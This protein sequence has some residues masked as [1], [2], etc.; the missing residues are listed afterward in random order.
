M[1]KKNLIKIRHAKSP[2]KINDAE[3]ACTKIISALRF[4]YRPN[5]WMTP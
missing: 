3:S 4:D 1:F 2:R 5:D